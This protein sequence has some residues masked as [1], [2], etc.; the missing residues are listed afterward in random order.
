MRRIISFDIDMTL[1]DHATW[2]IPDSAMEA[3]ERLRENH[4]I[5]VASGRDMDGDYSREIR[6]MI[7]PE[8]IIHMNG[9]RVTAGNKVIYE[10]FFDK[11]LLKELFLFA[12]DYSFSIGASLNGK[13]YY[14]NPD[15]VTAHD[16]RRWGCTDRNFAD[17]EELLELPV[18]ALAF[19]GDEDSAGIIEK[20]FPQVRLFMFAGKQG[21][22]LVEREASKAAGL[23]KLCDYYN[24]EESE[25]V[26]FGD[27]MNDIEIIR[28]AGIGIAMG[29]A[30][31][32][33]KEAADF[34]TS[35]IASDGI[36]N[37]CVKYNFFEK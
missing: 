27:S 12:K 25:C 11:K 2:K 29:N 16:L 10:H 23:K 20:H 1:L 5:A 15:T 7:N 6:D 28:S 17:A 36:W 9:T 19:L 33:V 22:D 21:A 14:S 13:D 18:Y 32:E 26:A 34:V 8:A 31:D 37:A 4:I 30:I 24:I 3:L 35:D